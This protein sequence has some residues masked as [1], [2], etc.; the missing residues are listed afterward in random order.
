MSRLWNPQPEEA[1]KEGRKQRITRQEPEVPSRI[2]GKRVLKGEEL[3][4]GLLTRGV[5]Q[6]LTKAAE[7]AP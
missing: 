3:Q 7:P 2:V 1:E 6:M 4:G 5:T